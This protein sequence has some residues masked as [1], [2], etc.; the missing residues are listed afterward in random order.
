MAEE[1]KRIEQLEKT[2]KEADRLERQRQAQATQA[3]NEPIRGLA[4]LQTTEQQ[5]KSSMTPAFLEQVLNKN[6]TR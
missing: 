2:R 4:S 5:R 1:Q 3:S 6:Q